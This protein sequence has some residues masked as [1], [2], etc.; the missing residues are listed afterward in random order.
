MVP[1]V[2]LFYSHMQGLS[3]NGESYLFV[4][5]GVGTG[6]PPMRLGSPPEI[7]QIRLRSS[8]K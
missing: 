6:G 2:R 5:R 1:L 4:S 8:Q 7:V 3:R